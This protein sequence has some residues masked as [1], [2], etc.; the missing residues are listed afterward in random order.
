LY[1]KA[2]EYYRYK[3]EREKKNAKEEVY[4]QIRLDFFLKM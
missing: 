1:R 3:E 4:M 2:S